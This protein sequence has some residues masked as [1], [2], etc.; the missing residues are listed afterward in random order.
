MFCGFMKANLVNGMTCG[1]KFHAAYFN[2]Y[3][4]SL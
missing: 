1:E 2:R 4:K 3:P